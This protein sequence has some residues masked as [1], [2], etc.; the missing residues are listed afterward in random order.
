MNANNR[1]L[2]AYVPAYA[3]APSGPTQSDLAVPLQVYIIETIERDA[4]N[5]LL[6]QLAIVVALVA[7]IFMSQWPVAFSSANAVP[8]PSVSAK[9]PGTLAASPVLIERLMFAPRLMATQGH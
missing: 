2:S 9:R 1:A 3:S 8:T 5:R 4:R 7:G 6:R